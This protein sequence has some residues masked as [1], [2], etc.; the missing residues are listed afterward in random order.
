MNKSIT[1]EKCG[2]LMFYKK[3]NNEYI[4]SNCD[5]TTTIPDFILNYSYKNKKDENNGINNIID[6]YNQY[7]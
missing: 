6:F 7:K 1:C 5:N 3:R 4:C 2:H